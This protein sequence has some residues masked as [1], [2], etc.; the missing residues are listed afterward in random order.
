MKRD[1]ENDLIDWKNKPNRKP[2]L[3]RGARQ[4]GKSFIIETFGHNHF[5][6]CI[7]IN[8]ELSPEFISCFQ[9]LDPN[10][11]IQSITL[12]LKQDITP[13]QTLLFLDE[14]QLCPQA[15]QALRYFKEKMPALHVIGAGSFLEFVINDAHY[16]EPVGRVQS[17][18][19]KPC[20]FKEY[21]QATGDNRLTE[22]L[23]NIT[24]NDTIDDAIHQALLARCKE[25]CV[26]GGMPEV[27]DFYIKHN[28]LL[29]C[30]EIQSTILEYYQ[31]DFS[32]YANKINKTTLEKIFSKT[33]AM[34]AKHFKYVDIDP[35]ISARDQK[36]ALD[37]LLKA[38]VIHRIS[39]TKANG[40]PLQQDDKKFKLL[41]LD[42]GLASHAMNIDMHTLLNSDLMLLNRGALAEQFV[43]QELLAYEKKY[44][45]AKLYY[46]E[47]EKR[48]SQAE[49]DYITHIG[50]YIY[51]IEVKAGAT[52]RLKSLQV[53]LD[54]KK[55]D[56]GIQISQNKL[57]FERR[58]LSVPLYMIHELPRIIKS[59]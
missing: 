37:A 20:S 44:K 49:V 45:Q 32:K 26:L 58:V 28:K 23:A 9:S 18:Y 55:I 52:G 41:F 12:L 3:V 7:V 47:R 51:P 6:Q 42:I 35:D 24:L 53:F 27:L 13:G 30:E 46:W 11:I 8:F 33:P 17:L 48:S 4:V 50:P 57:S 40:L 19:M 38:G 21:L 5:E 34:L 16:Q 10:K 36:P 54:E 39:R 25:Y 43:G 59:L 14:I 15:I 31:R 56:I 1:I 29:G 22:F 2:L